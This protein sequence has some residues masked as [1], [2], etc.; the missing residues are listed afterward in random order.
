MKLK[1]AFSKTEINAHTWLCTNKKENLNKGV[2]CVYMVVKKSSIIYIGAT[3]CI[4]SR[5]LTN[6][7]ID[8]GC[9]IYY[10]VLSNGWFKLENK[11]IKLV[12]PKLNQKT[13]RRKLPESEKL[14]QVCVWVQQKYLHIVVPKLLAIA[15]KYR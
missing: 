7:H 14:V 4:R 12:N 3:K 1:V 10:T 8:N 9:I 2:H 15:S 6:G 13:G 11:L 5:L